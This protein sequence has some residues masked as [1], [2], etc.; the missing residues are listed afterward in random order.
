MLVF[1]CVDESAEIN[2]F[3]DFVAWLFDWNSNTKKKTNPM[4]Q[5][6]K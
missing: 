4:F 6:N 3:H 2:E 5:L 1:I